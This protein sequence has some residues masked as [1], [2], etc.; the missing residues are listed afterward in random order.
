LE[1]LGALSVPISE[2]NPKPPN[3]T[4]TPDNMTISNKFG[5][6]LVMSGVANADGQ[7]MHNN[8]REMITV[9]KR[10]VITCKR[11]ER[12]RLEKKYERYCPPMLEM[13]LQPV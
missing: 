11:T 9:R 1:S 3:N 4:P 12:N 2:I 7:K 5:E 8:N 6:E 13:S 10:K